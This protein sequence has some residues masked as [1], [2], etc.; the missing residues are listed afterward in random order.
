MPCSRSIGGATILDSGTAWREHRQP[1]AP[2]LAYSPHRPSKDVR[3]SGTW[4]SEAFVPSLGSRP[5]D[6]RVFFCGA[7]F[8][9]FAFGKTTPGHQLSGTR[10]VPIGSTQKHRMIAF[11]RHL[12]GRS[13]LLRNVDFFVLFAFHNKREPRL[14]QQPTFQKT[15]KDH[16]SNEH[17]TE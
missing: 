13:L 12:T 8:L 10:P 15:I 14:A 17:P 7:C 3:L 2:Q 11:A 6:L 1:Q 4:S 16:R 5:S 9:S